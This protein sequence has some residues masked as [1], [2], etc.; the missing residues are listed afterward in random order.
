MRRLKGEGRQGEA[1][2]PLSGKPDAVLDPRTWGSRP[3]LKADAYRLSH[4]GTPLTVLLS[5]PLSQGVPGGVQ[6]AFTCGGGTEPCIMGGRL[7]SPIG[8]DSF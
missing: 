5:T 1:D 3:E 4:P 6:Y 8:P 2:S 7:E